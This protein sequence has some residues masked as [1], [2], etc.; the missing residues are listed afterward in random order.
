MNAAIAERTAR[1]HTQTRRVKQRRRNFRV[2]HAQERIKLL[3]AAYEL[4]SRV[5]ATA[6]RRKKLATSPFST[7]TSRGCHWRV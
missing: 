6:D 5:Y 3:D 4:A 7:S 2:V 1:G